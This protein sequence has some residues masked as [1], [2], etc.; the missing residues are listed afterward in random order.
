MP[1]CR[2]HCRETTWG[3]HY[4][5]DRNDGSTV[6]LEVISKEH[7]RVFPD[8]STEWKSPSLCCYEQRWELESL[9]R[10]NPGFEVKDQVKRLAPFNC[11][12]KWQNSPGV[13]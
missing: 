11:V 4:S 9:A 8:R 7:S 5:P 2:S 3:G 1:P 13:G 6:G 12:R 10:E